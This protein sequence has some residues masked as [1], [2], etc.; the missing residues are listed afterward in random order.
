[1]STAYFAIRDGARRKIAPCAFMGY[2]DENGFEI[3]IVPKAST[4]DVPAF[5]VPFVE[6]DE[7]HIDGDLALRWVRERVPPPGRQNIGEVLAAHGL[8]E[9]SELALL[10]SGQGESSQDSFVVEEIDEANFEARIVD[11][12]AQRRR[13]LGDAIRSRRMSLGMS[14]RELADMVGIDQPALSRI[15]SGKVNVTFD[16]LADIDGALSG[17]GRP[18]LNLTRRALW[19]AERRELYGFIECCAP[20][21]AQ[22]YARL[23]DELEA[24]FDDA[25]S[26]VADLRVISHC[27]RDLGD[28]SF[29]RGGDMPAAGEC[30][31]KLN[32]LEDVLRDRFSKLAGAHSELF[33]L[34]DKANRV[35]VRG[36]YAAPTQSQIEV[37]ITLLEASDVQDAVICKLQNPYWRD[38]LR[39][40]GLCESL[41]RHDEDDASE[42]SYHILDLPK[43]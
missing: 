27:F 36:R 16:L 34:V 10:R 1:M 26:A 30:Q 25:S 23:V 40:M 31:D 24:Y 9:Y 22:V 8:S 3:D 14:Q 43:D 7:R 42:P 35:D 2:D 38:A 5:F 33:D 15:E 13:E 12:R 20:S 11:C 4:D 17:S 6:R 37:F 41:Q 21:L 18:I 19:N 32:A 29:G 28:T 39:D